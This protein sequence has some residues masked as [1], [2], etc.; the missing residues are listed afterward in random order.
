MIMTLTELVV[1]L[2][3]APPTQIDPPIRELIYKV[4]LTNETAVREMLAEVYKSG[5]YASVTPFVA[6][7]CDPK[8]TK[9]Y[10]LN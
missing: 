8:F 5:F 7:L 3:T 4:D 1:M 6:T 10:P 9:D 2:R